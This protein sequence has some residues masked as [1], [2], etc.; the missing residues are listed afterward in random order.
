MSMTR[1]CFLGLAAVVF[2]AGGEPAN[3]DRVPGGIMNMADWTGT[4]DVTMT[5]KYSTCGGVNHGAV[6]RASFAITESGRRTWV[7]EVPYGQGN[8]P[9]SY[10]LVKQSY[11]LSGAILHFRERTKGWEAGLNLSVAT[12]NQMTGLR[13]VVNKGA[14]CGIVYDVSGV[15]LVDGAGNRIGSTPSVDEP[16]EAPPTPRHKRMKPRSGFVWVQ[17]HWEWR[18][19]TYAWAPG[20]WERARSGYS[21]RQGRWDRRGNRWVWEPGRWE[22][23]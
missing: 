7:K 12:Q 16:T 18:N 10:A 11:G 3:A 17:G 5:A 1:G 8:D 4:W 20:H 14:M 2:V 19:G 9:I 21:Y 22:R 13:V 6:R 23:Q 15:R